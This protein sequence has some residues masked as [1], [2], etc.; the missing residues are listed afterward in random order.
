MPR[1]QFPLAGRVIVITGVSRR[2]GIGYAIARRAAEWGADLVCHHFSTHDDK[3]P[4]GSDDIAAVCAGIRSH[5]RSGARMIDVGG[6]L[7]DEGAPAA[8]IDTAHSEYGRVDAVVCNQALSG[9][10]GALSDITADDLDAHW[11]VNARTSILLAQAF[12]AVAG[13]QGSIVFMTSGQA[14]GPMRGEIAYAASKA[15]IAGI[16]L[17]LSDELAAKNIRVNTVNPGPVDTGYM[18]DE[19]RRHV[20]EQFPGGRMATPDDPARLVVWLLSDESQWV[21]G[22]VINTEGG[23]SRWK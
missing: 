6:D 2:A 4:W 14:M 20:L 7:T 18:T 11:R 12:A 15:A 17:T 8:L 10:D 21:T 19:V 9:N 3:Q 1:D 22:Q 23:F 5:L 13:D 16:T